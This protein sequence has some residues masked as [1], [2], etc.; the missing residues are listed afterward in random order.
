MNKQVTFGKCPGR[1]LQEQITSSEQLQTVIAMYNQEMSRGRVTPNYQKFK[2]MVKQYMDQTIR[3]RNFKTRN[4]R[5]ETGV[6]VKSQK[7]RNVSVESKV[8]ECTQWKV[9]GQCS[10]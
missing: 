3:T 5:I 10:R 2:N 7:R 6:L 4:E 1:S 8:G 9:N